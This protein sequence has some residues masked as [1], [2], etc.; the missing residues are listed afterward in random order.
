M[1]IKM[2]KIFQSSLYQL[3]DFIKKM[4]NKKKEIDKEIIKDICLSAVIHDP[5]F[6]NNFIYIEKVENK[7]YDLKL[8]NEDTGLWYPIKIEFT[9]ILSD[10]HLSCKESLIFSLTGIESDHVTKNSHWTKIID[11]IKTNHI[12]EYNDVFYIVIDKEKKENIIINTL[13]S[14]KNV[15]ININHFPFL[16]NWSINNDFDKE[17]IIPTKELFN[18]FQ[19]LVTLFENKTKK[20]H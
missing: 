12:K 15:Q 20:E 9:D 18:K 7:W 5:W 6:E 17:K 11:I 1:N 16:I 2:V 3:K 13:K 8:I 19:E 10:Y 14:L 4:I